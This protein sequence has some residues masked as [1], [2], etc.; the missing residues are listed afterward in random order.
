MH[1]LL[2]RRL[3]V[4]LGFAVATFSVHSAA[5]QASLYRVDQRYGTVGFSITSLGLFSTEGRFAR[6]EGQLLL[7]PDHPEQ[8]RIEVTIDGN[9][10]EMPLDDEVSML[11]SP[12]YFDTSRYPTERF[13]S[14]SIQEVA[15]SH[16]LIHGTLQVRGVV[17]P[18]D[19]DAVMTERHVDTAKHIQWADFVVTGQMR[20]SA[21]GMTAD[22]TMVS[23]AVHLKIRI[24]LTVG[25]DP[26]AG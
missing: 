25:V 10:V 24:R 3:L 21:F 6:F 13:V 17:N 12:S 16:Y 19:L 8:T 23:D 2:S 1:C 11:R 22:Q 5:A 20:R 4:L 7:D 15:P 18:Q 26:K 14:T 9:S